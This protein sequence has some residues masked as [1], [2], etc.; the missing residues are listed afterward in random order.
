M[1]EDA[2]QHRRDDLEKR[3]RACY[4]KWVWWGWSWTFLSAG[5]IWSVVHSW[6]WWISLFL[7]G[8]VFHISKRFW[9]WPF[10]RWLIWFDRRSS[11]PYLIE[12]TVEFTQNTLPKINQ[13][14]IHFLSKRP[15]FDAILLPQTRRVINHHPHLIPPWPI[16]YFLVW[17][18]F[19]ALLFTPPP[20]G[21]WLLNDS[22]DQSWSSVIALW[23]RFEG[24][25]SSGKNSSLPTQSTS[26]E[27]NAQKPDPQQ[28]VSK[29]PFPLE[30]ID[31]IDLNTSLTDSDS[32]S[33]TK[34]SQTAQ[35]SERQKKASS[36]AP[37]QTEKAP[38]SSTAYQ[39]QKRRQAQSGGQASRGHTL[40]E[41]E[42][43]QYTLQSSSSASS[44]TPSIPSKFKTLKPLKRLQPT[45]LPKNSPPLTPQHFPVRF[46]SLL[47]PS[48]S[49]RI[50]P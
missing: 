23:S 14:Q 17:I 22:F 44:P 16:K 10:E 39:R 21:T 50:N 15:P 9:I 2:G 37:L 5:F 18:L 36:K 19:S 43:R 12:S 46:Q 25:S 30:K 11:T 34:S 3:L 7:S 8:V 1:D 45:L 38:P 20:K 28:K 27:K 29:K 48:P 49:S 35:S 6:S 4:Q 40:S 24:L 32:T 33:K 13:K 42:L 31:R 47:Q 41:L 26:Q